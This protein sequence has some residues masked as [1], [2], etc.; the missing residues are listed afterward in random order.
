MKN[1]SIHGISRRMG[2]LFLAT[3][4]VVSITEINAQQSIPYRWKNVVILGGG[5]VTGI[6]FSPAAK[7][8]IYARTDVGGRISLEPTYKQLDS[9]NR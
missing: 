5:F 2:L 4:I 6:V 7:D 8:I 3:I 1:I 9:H